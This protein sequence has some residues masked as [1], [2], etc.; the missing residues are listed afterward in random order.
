MFWTLNATYWFQLYTYPYTGMIGWQVRLF[1]RDI[2]C[3][4]CLLMDLVSMSLYKIK[5]G[6][7]F[8]VVHLRHIFPTCRCIGFVKFDMSHADHIFKGPIS[9]FSGTFLHYIL[10]DMWA[11]EL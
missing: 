6:M 9:Y 10:C 2:F 4:Q 1:D 7:W 5:I 8:D 11:F 3:G